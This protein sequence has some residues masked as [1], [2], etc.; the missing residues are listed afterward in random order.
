MVLLESE[1]DIT[2][3]FISTQ[4]HSKEETDIL[5]QP[6]KENDLKK[7]SL[8]RLSKPAMLDKEIILGRLG[9]LKDM[10]QVNNN[11]KILLQPD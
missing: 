10:K 1:F 9:T 3:S 11:L 7:E 6:D 5:L 8:V 2:C 4:I